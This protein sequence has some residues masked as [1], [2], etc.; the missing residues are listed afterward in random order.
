MLVVESTYGNRLH[1]P[2]NDTIDELVFV[3]EDTLRPRQGNI[4]IPASALGRTQE[5]LH[6]LLDLC[7]LGK[8]PRMQVFVDSP[9]ADKVT[10]ITWQHR[11]FL[12]VEAPAPGTRVDL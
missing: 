1:R 5:L 7:R 3:I 6:L 11:E 4:I 12:D 9:M 8:L 10:E 2:L